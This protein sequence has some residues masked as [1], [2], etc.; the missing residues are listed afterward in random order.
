MGSLQ[1]ISQYQQLN[2]AAYLYILQA[3]PMVEAIRKSKEIQGFALPSPPGKQNP[4]EKMSLFADDTQITNEES[5]NEE[6]VKKAF[7][8][9][10]LFAKTSSGKENYT[11]TKGL[12]IQEDEETNQKFKR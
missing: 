2:E 12:Y 6:S 11:K 9:L 3:E 8:V 5:V 1:G 10:E 7:E 4:E